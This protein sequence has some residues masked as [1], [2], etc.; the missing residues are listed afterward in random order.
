MV[1]K[2]GAGIVEALTA[3]TIAWQREKGQDGQRSSRPDHESQYQHVVLHIMSRS[4]RSTLSH[5]KMFL[6]VHVHL[7]RFEFKVR[8]RKSVQHTHPHGS[9]SR[10]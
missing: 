3:G 10:E 2:V 1:R 4:A 5:S 8:L 9:G 7:T 6:C